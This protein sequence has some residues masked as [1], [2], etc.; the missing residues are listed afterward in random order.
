MLYLDHAATTPVRREV[1]EAMWP[2]LTGE[3]GNPSSAHTVG[4]R[5][6]SALADGRA[7]AA[8]VLG[9]RASDV[10]FTSGGTEADNL[11]VKGIALG[12]TRGRHIVTAATEHEAV[13]ASVDY[14]CRLHGFEVTF[15]ELGSDGLV[16]PAALDAALRPDTALVSLMYA[17]NE[18]G[19]VQDLATL[20]AVTSAHGI[21][22]HTDAVQAAGWLDLRVQQHGIDALTLAGH[23]IGAPKGIGLAWIRGRLP[24]EPL[25]HGGGQERGRRSGTEN[26]AF[27]VGLAAALELAEAERKDASRHTSVLRDAVI[28]RVLREIPGSTL[29]GSATS[30]LPNSASF[31][32]PGTSGEAILLELERRGFVSSS[33]SACAAGSDEPSHVLTALGF[34]AD[35]ARTAVRLTFAADLTTDQADAVATALAA[36]VAAVSGV[37]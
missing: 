13:L 7:R 16:D 28:G 12:S 9:V 2:Y 18:I 6:A 26:V 31:C 10:V 3:F 17:N 22:I 8:A 30:R 11:A 15:V 29:T 5:A 23:K 27:A 25:V 4:E 32:F 24:V 37:A 33:G 14:L 20:G 21:P 34:P 19:T 36:S 1:L 35:L